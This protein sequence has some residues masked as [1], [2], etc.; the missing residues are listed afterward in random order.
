MFSLFNITLTIYLDFLREYFEKKSLS[1]L[2][3]VIRRL[4]SLP[5]YNLCLYF[6]NFRDRSPGIPQASGFLTKKQC[7]EIKQGMLY[8]S[9]DPCTAYG[10]RLGSRG[11]TQ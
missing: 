8:L 11:E 1:F 10:I 9:D 5:V 2:S 7:K 6:L 4:S 3:L